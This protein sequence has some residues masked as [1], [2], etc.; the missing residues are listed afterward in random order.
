MKREHEVEVFCD[1]NSYPED[2][3][4]GVKLRF[5]FCTKTGNAN[6]Y[7][8]ESVAGAIKDKCGIVLC[9]GQENAIAL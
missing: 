9:C 5:T 1:K 2:L 4:K 3:F 6:K 7:C 8:F